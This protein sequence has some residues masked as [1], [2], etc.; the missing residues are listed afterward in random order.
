M[1]RYFFFWH[2]ATNLFRS[3]QAVGTGLRYSLANEHQRARIS[4][5]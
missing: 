4:S 3:I 5:S 1:F 2:A